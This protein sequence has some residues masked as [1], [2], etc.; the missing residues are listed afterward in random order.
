M[1][2]EK[3]LFVFLISL[4]VIIPQVLANEGEVCDSSATPQQGGS[5]NPNDYDVILN[6]PT[7]VSSQEAGSQQR[8]CGAATFG[9]AMIRSNP[10]NNN[11]Q[12]QTRENVINACSAAGHIGQGGAGKFDEYLEAMILYL[13]Q[14]PLNYYEVVIMRTENYTDPVVRIRPTPQIS[15]RNNVRLFLYRP[16]NFGSAD[17]TEGIRT[18]NVGAGGIG[19]GGVEYDQNNIDVAAHM[20]QPTAIESNGHVFGA[21]RRY[22]LQ[23]YDPF[24]GSRS[25]IEI[26]ADTIGRNY[27]SFW[28]DNQGGTRWFNLEELFYVKNLGPYNNSFNWTGNNTGGS[29]GGSSRV[30]RGPATGMVVLRPPI[31]LPNPIP[32]SGPTTPTPCGAIDRVTNT[33]NIFATCP[34]NNYCSFAQGCTCKAR[35]CG[36]GVVDPGEQCDDRNRNNND[37]CSAQCQAE[38]MC[39]SRWILLNQQECDPPGSACLR[40]GHGSIAR[41]TCDNFCKCGPISIGDPRE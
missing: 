2:K 3:M 27:A 14:D 37:G 30:V 21:E 26:A 12:P 40:I 9:A 7:P 17:I 13:N 41:G 15:Y 39:G 16:Y 10:L 18:V 5:Q 6:G 4:F 25:D 20:V 22:N 19:L 29:S 31:P 11:G 28:G 36:D 35:I 38:V 23:V 8:A 1:K 24:F 32:V 34:Q 33:C